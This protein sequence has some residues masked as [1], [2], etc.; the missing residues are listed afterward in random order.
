M[1]AIF[2]KIDA[3][4]RAIVEF[5][6][7]RFELAWRHFDLHARQR[8]TMF[9]FFILLT[10]FLFGGCFI[11]FKEREVVGSFPGIFAAGAGALL[12]FIFFMLDQ[13]NKQL[14]RVSKRALGLLETQFLFA[15]YRP[16]K[17]SGSDYPGVISAETQSYG[18][19]NLLKHS[20]LMGSVYWLAVL[21]FLALA[22][23][24]LAVRQG[25]IKLPLPSALSTSQ[26]SSGLPG[27]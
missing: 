15:S 20:L 11:L 23:Y 2:E 13:R 21:M 9:H 17:V 3:D 27:R 26:P 6:K 19:N 12:A 24:F 14:Y 7:I 18:D 16:L 8:T 4:S 25:C 22:G 5:E 1:S 10:P